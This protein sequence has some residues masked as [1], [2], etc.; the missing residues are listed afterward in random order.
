MPKGQKSQIEEA[1]TAQIR[2]NLSTE[3]IIAKY[4]NLLI[5]TII[6]EFIVILMNKWGRRES[7]L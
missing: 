2:G 4:Y 6:Y 1:H 3:I 7:Y 5:K